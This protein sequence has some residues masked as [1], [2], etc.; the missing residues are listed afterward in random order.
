MTRQLGTAQGLT[1]I[2]SLLISDLQQIEDQNVQRALYQVQNWANSLGLVNG[3]TGG[4][5]AS[6]GTNCPAATPGHPATWTIVSL[7]GVAAYIPVW[8]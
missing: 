4:G 8:T 6:L 3:K 1:G 7:N 5:T 2:P